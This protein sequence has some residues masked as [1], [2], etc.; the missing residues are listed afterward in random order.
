[1]LFGTDEGEEESMGREAGG[2]ATDGAATEV[3][4][5]S[6]KVC[7]PHVLRAPSMQSLVP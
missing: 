1:M 4:D 7:I 5:S 6:D 3:A 2:G